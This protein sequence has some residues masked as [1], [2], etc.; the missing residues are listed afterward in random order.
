METIGSQGTSGSGQID[1]IPCA[2]TVLV[3]VFV[4]IEEVP[5]ES[6]SG[7]GVIESS[8]VPAEGDGSRGVESSM[9]I[10]KEGR[11][12]VTSGSGHLWGYACHE[13]GF[14]SRQ[15]ITRWLAPGG[16]RLI[17]DRIQLLIGPDGSELTWAADGGFGSIGF[18][19]VEHE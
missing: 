16:R 2:A 5:P 15:S 10:A 7:D 6:E 19:I 8:G 4:G 12:G 11:L 17:F 18:E 3:G 1:Q 9:D 14:R 13:A